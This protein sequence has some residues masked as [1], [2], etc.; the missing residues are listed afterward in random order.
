MVH[1]S[2]RILWQC[3]NEERWKNDLRNFV[4]PWLHMRCYDASKRRTA[5]R[6]ETRGVA[7]SV[8]G[9]GAGGFSSSG[10]SRASRLYILRLI[11]RKNMVNRAK[12]HAILDER[13]KESVYTTGVEYERCGVR[14]ENSASCAGRV[15]RGG[16]GEGTSLF[17]PFDQ[18]P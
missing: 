9:S 5:A 16:C 18:W 15:A 12:V 17:A 3:P 2:D 1:T 4:P 10:P 6:T 7:R 14:H 11:F 13:F 8:A